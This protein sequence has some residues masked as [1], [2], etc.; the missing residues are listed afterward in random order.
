MQ[1]TINQNTFDN[2]GDISYLCSCQLNQGF[3]KNVSHDEDTYSCDTF[4]T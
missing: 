3:I 1:L 4:K 2:F